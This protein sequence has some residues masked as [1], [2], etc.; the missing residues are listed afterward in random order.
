M[1]VDCAGNGPE[2]RC[3]GRLVRVWRLRDGDIGVA[4][5]QREGGLARHARGLS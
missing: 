2:V 4:T 3:A 1:P 5:L